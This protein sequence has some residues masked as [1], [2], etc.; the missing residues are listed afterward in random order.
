MDPAQER[1][2]WLMAEVALGKQ[3][4]L[5]PLVR[6]YA[7]RLLTFIDRMVGDLH[8]SEEI[9][10]EVFLAVWIKRRQYTFPRPFKA[11]LF[12]IALNHSRSSFRGRRLSTVALKDDQAP[13]LAESSPVEAAIST[14]TAALLTAAVTQLPPQQRA[15]VA[16]RIWDGLSYA[17]IA[18]V[19]ER[20]ES[21]VRAHMH[22]GLTALRRQLE[23]RL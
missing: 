7:S 1:D 6:R 15:V 4:S 12:G 21:T 17:E 22:H 5:E 23:S 14:E 19:L 13:A 2:E 18:S 9:V 16:L 3:D 20:E 8:R 10:Q 11:W